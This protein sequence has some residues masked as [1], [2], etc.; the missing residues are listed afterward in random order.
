MDQ[1]GPNRLAL[2]NGSGKISIAQFDP[3]T[4]LDYQL[5]FIRKTFN[6][7]LHGII[8][9]S[10]SNTFTVATSQVDS[11]KFPDDE[12]SALTDNL[13]WKPAAHIERAEL[14]VPSIPKMSLKLLSPTSWS[15]VDEFAVEPFEH[16]TALEACSLATKETT[17]GSKSF[18]CVGATAVKGEDRPVRGRVLIFDIMDVVPE[19]GRPETNVKFKLLL[20]SD[21]KLPVSGLA[22]IDGYLA[23]SLGV[24][25][26]IHEFEDNETLNG[27]AF[28]DCG[29]YLTSM[30]I[31]KKYLVLGDIKRGLNFYGFQEKPPKVLE[32]GRDLDVAPKPVL[33]SAALLDGQEVLFVA[34]DEDG[35]LSFFVYSPA[36]SAERLV[37]RGCYDLHEPVSKMTRVVLETAANVQHATLYMTVKGEI[38]LLTPLSESQ[39]RTLYSA[40]NR[41][42]QE[43]PQPAGLH[44]RASRGLPTAKSVLDLGLLG[45]TVDVPL[46]AQKALADEASSS[47][48]SVIKAIYNPFIN[49]FRKF[50]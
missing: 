31:L 10:S 11:F 14:T 8:Y 20:S 44:P 21:M 32:L 41:I 22:D 43:I 39:F 47:I 33:H 12:Y 24:K 17:K 36:T 3:N 2:L 19:P 45:Q 15:F 9:N 30:L 34:A 16:I 28:T 7:K 49:I 38:G 26:I 18:I 48:Y 37:K 6:E 42:S 23:V 35:L 29:V 50:E 46:L 4:Q 27:V 40:Q 25:T 5:P 13:E 1:F